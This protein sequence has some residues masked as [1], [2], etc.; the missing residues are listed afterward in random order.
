MKYKIGLSAYREGQWVLG[1][2]HRNTDQ[3]FLLPCPNNKRDAPT[4]LPLIY[5]WNLPGSI[6]YTDEWGAYNDLTAAAYTHQDPLETTHLKMLKW[7]LGVHRKAN[8]NFCYGD[9]G[10]TPWAIEVIPQ[11]I[12]YFVRASQATTGSV[13]TLLHHTFMEQRQLKLTW[14]NTWSSIVR[15]SS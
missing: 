12:S 11:C 13:N 8:N 7:I 9:T 15:E 5:R 4:L 14:Y 3:C 1:G 2:V 10:R 6:V